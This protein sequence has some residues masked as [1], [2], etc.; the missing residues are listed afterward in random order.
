MSKTKLFLVLGA[1]AIALA[2]A[3]GLLAQTNPTDGYGAWTQEAQSRNIPAGTVNDPGSHLT[4][5]LDTGVNARK[6]FGTALRTKTSSVLV[7]M[8][9]RLDADGDGNLD[10][11]A[12]VQ[13]FVAISNTHPTM[14][15]TIHFRYYNDNCEDVLDFLVLLT[16]NDTLM[17][18][19]FNYVIPGTGG[20]NTS[21]RFFKPSAN[22]VLKPISTVDW[23]SGRFVLTAAA[24]GA[25]IDGDDDAEILFPFELGVAQDEFCNVEKD[26][27]WGPLPATLAGTAKNVGVAAGLVWN[28]LHVFNASQISFNYL[29]GIQTYAKPVQVGGALNFQ[30]GGINAWIRPAIDRTEFDNNTNL[31]GR[32][33]GDS[34][35]AP[36]G[37]LVLGSEGLTQYPGGA[38]FN[39]NN[40]YYLRN[41][42]H[43]GDL[44][45]ANGN[46][47]S[48]YGAQGTAPFFSA[49]TQATD[50][51][52]HFLSVADDYN[53][54]T[55]VGA[56]GAAA[57]FPDKASN[58]EPAAT[59]YVM[60]IYDNDEDPLILTTDPP[61]NVSPPVIGQVAQLKI[62]CI[63]LRTFFTTT[64]AAGTN[65]DDFTVAE[66]VPTVPAIVAGDGKK[67]DG[68]FKAKGGDISGGWIRF[69][70]D[71]TVRIDITANG[72][73][74]DGLAPGV[75]LG[76]YLFAAEGT[77][78]IDAPSFRDHT[79]GASFLTI[80]NAYSVQGGFG[81]LW[82]NFA[83][84]SSAR[85]SEAGNPGLDLAPGH[86]GN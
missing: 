85:V 11:L 47:W 59:V 21:N 24:S 50:M 22:Q 71:N 27:D 28:N 39:I 63:C 15:V 23:G 70:R 77:S 20:L 55:N 16:C 81:A 7:D 10:P 73:N 54:S 80:S 79:F 18:D 53:G 1:M 31:A 40:R 76:R 65:L 62:T 36:T 58:I 3:P 17:F 78:T 75:D 72:A 4:Y 14:S 43:G 46:S 52:I 51:V 44:R 8:A 2:V 48:Y 37:K 61:L 60:Q 29:V 13:N 56:L 30:S 84:P 26:G 33:D 82:W 35:F 25:N 49:A 42:V 68:L 12:L 45:W 6:E 32:P 57:L 74:G 83:V 9:A 34:V 67:F 66:L 19:P 64:I 5:I 38:A 86:T 41:E 69:V